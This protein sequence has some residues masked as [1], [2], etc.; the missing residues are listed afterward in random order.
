MKAR[1]NRYRVYVGE[2]AD[3]SLYVGSTAK[4]VRARWAEHMRGDG[5]RRTRK[6]KA[7]RLLANGQSGYA[8]TRRNAE[9]LENKIARQLRRQGYRVHCGG[10]E[11]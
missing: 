8:L 1:P 11:R 2:L 3:G 7:G 4:S 5:G 10:C 9:R 6:L